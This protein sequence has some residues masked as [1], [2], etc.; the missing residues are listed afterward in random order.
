MAATTQAQIQIAVI[1]TLR[2][3]IAIQE[4]GEVPPEFEAMTGVPGFDVAMLP[5]QPKQPIEIGQVRRLV[6]EVTELAAAHYQK[7]VLAYAR[8]FMALAAQARI[9]GADPAEALQDLAL[10]TAAGHGED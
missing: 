3:A 2:A 9:H 10:R 8:A 6:S 5:G 7:V 4:T 1:D